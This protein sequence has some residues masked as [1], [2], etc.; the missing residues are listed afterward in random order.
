MLTG[1]QM[2]TYRFIRRCILLEGRA[3]TYRRIGLVT[4]KSC[5]EVHAMVSRICERQWLARLGRRIFLKRDLPAP[6]TVAE[7]DYFAL[8]YDN[9]TDTG[10][11][12]LVDLGPA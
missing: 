11:P 6:T 7:W 4:G 8:D 1:K 5:G 2:K 12:R 9:L 10:W 3:P